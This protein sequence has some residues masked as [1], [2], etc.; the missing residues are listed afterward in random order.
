MDA[1]DGNYE[2]ILPALEILKE[3]VSYDLYIKS[4]RSGRTLLSRM[5]LKAKYHTV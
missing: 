1:S 3:D 2:G 4:V 5:R